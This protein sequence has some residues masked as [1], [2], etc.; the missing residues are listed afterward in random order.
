[1]TNVVD[2]L[3]Q[4]TP[5]DPEFAFFC[6]GCNCGH[7]F[8]TTGG[9]PRWTWNGDF[10]KPTIDPSILI[11]MTGKRCHSFVRDGQ[12]QF[13]IDCDHPLAGKTVH[14]EEF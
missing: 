14:L 5:D 1:M 3:E 4:E 12:I 7:W 13:L 10:Q 11:P 2:I 6:P 9:S 8:K